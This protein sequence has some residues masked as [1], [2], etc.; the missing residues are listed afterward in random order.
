MRLK[1]GDIEAEGRTIEE[2]A[3]LLEKAADFQ[4]ARGADQTTVL[5]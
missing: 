2:V 4:N 5:E 1:I 3:E